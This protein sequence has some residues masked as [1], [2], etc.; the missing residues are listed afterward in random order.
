MRSLQ[1]SHR[2]VQCQIGLLILSDYS[3]F[4]THSS[5][6]APLRIILSVNNLCL[7]CRADKCRQPQQR[8][9]CR[10]S[11]TRWYFDP[12]REAC[13]QFA[14]GGCLGN[15]NRFES[16]EECE[17]NCAASSVQ[18]ELNS[19]VCVCVCVCVR[20]CVRAFQAVLCL[21]R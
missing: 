9:P 17:S 7:L 4:L 21:S 3:V 15:D 19:G 6:S 1:V 16:L 8:G 2:T 10:G 12:A 5:R 14:Y 20:A 13:V 11:Y 18:G